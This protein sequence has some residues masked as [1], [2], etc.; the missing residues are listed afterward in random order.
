MPS[1]KHSMTTRKVERDVSTIH[2]LI[3]TPADASA[4]LSKLTRG[5]FTH[6]VEAQNDAKAC[7]ADPLWVNMPV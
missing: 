7:P 4:L 2:V 1:K 6:T 5:G 3:G